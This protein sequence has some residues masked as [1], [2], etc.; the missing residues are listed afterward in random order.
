[1]WVLFK[2]LVI[3]CIRFRRFEF[4]MINKEKF[5]LFKEVFGMICLKFFIELVRVK[6]IVEVLFLKV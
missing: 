3:S 6:K 4:L 5:L 1:M 2:V